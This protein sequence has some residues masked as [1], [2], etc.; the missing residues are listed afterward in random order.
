MDKRKLWVHLSAVKAENISLE[1]GRRNVYRVTSVKGKGAVQKT[2]DHQEAIAA[3][4]RFISGKLLQ[5]GL[6]GYVIGL[7]GGVDS[8]VSASLA[9]EAVG[10]D[11]VLGLLMP[12]RTSSESSIADALTLVDKLG[13]EH[14]RIDITPMIDAYFPEI[15][16][17][18]KLRAGNKMARERMAILFDVAQELDRMVLG[19]GN[20][21]EICLGYTTWYGDSACSINPVGQLYKTEIRLLAQALGVPE[22]IIAKPPTADLWVGQTDEGEIGVRYEEIDR[23]LQRIVDDGITSMSALEREGFNAADISRVVSLLNRNSFKRRLPDIAP[24]GREAI[25]DYIEL[26]E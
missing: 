5:S 4:K 19:T 22:S 12:Y 1:S 3:I 6:K 9:V 23:L 21:T 11:K 24:L 13:I 10:K 8:S 15:N 25:P 18:N 26:S 2:F 17:A 14:R 7:S 20:R 16:E